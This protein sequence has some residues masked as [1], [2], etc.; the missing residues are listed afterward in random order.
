MQSDH[1]LP[2]PALLEY[3]RFTF[4]FALTMLTYPLLLA[5]LFLPG[6]GWMI[7]WSHLNQESLPR[8]TPLERFIHQS[9]EY[10][11]MPVLVVLGL[12]VLILLMGL[13]STVT[14]VQAAAFCRRVMFSNL[15]FA[16]AVL[17]MLPL[18]EIA[19][20]FNDYNWHNWLY[21]QTF[22][23]PALGLALAW[24][25]YQLTTMQAHEI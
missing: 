16:V 19:R 23:M 5:V 4:N 21:L 6:H 1:Y 11:G 25:G 17:L 7:P 15:G 18:M 14:W 10:T 13:S 2:E 20:Q 8:I 22:I 12:S 24:L 9:I 3:R